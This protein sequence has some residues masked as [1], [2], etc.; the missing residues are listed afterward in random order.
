MIHAFRKGHIRFCPT[1]KRLYDFSLPTFWEHEPV[2]S[3]DS[4][5]ELV[6]R[7]WRSWNR[8]LQSPALI[9]L[10]QLVG[11]RDKRS[12]PHMWFLPQTSVKCSLP[13]SR[14]SELNINWISKLLATGAL[15]FVRE[16]LN[17]P[18][19]NPRSQRPS[20]AI[21]RVVD[22]DR[23]CILS[24]SSI[25][26]GPGTYV[27]LSYVWGPQLG[28]GACSHRGGAISMDELPATIADAIRFVRKIGKRYLWVDR[29]CVE[30]EDHIIKARQLAMMGSIYSSAWV[31]LV[32][33][34]A[35]QSPLP[36][37]S[38]P[39]R[40]YP[41]LPVRG[42]TMIP[43]SDHLELAIRSAS[44]AQRAWTFSE[45]VA[46]P[47]L[48]FFLPHTMVLLTRETYFVE[49]MRLDYLNS[50]IYEDMYIGPNASHSPRLPLLS[51]RNA[52]E[53]LGVAF[54]MYQ[55]RNLTFEQDALAGFG[56]W[57]RE[58][59]VPH[60]C[61]IPWLPYRVELN[62]QPKDFELSVRFLAGL[63]WSQRDRIEHIVAEASAS[64]LKP[65]DGADRCFCAAFPS[66]SWAKC[67]QYAS[68]R[69]RKPSILWSFVC[70]RVDICVD[71]F[72]QVSA[73][74]ALEMVVEHA[75]FAYT[76]TRIIYSGWQGR[77]Q[78]GSG[79]PHQHLNRCGNGSIS[80]QDGPITWTDSAEAYLDLPSCQHQPLPRCTASHLAILI[81][82]DYNGN[83][84]SD[85]G[86]R[87]FWWMLLD[88][89]PNGD[90]RRVG[91]ART[92]TLGGRWHSRMVDIEESVKRLPRTRLIIV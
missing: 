13:S 37:I 22:C 39:R 6:T 74:R 26:T 14:R 56:V 12:S 16:S 48:L 30:Q 49:P 88:K 52:T 65:L 46:S 69:Q 92:G 41:H 87:H 66:W 5:F 57:L 71:Q 47:R 38:T 89:H 72:R 61:G 82:A 21:F 78:D 24:S 55:A 91:I 62:E 63:L 40:P 33:L 35:S 45:A 15:T 81:L 84:A 79:R 20:Q 27:A 58:A 86:W 90:W 7:N 8:S 83:S 28:S 2:A 10:R 85:S 34:E 44:W 4:R 1:L 11:H 31:T 3:G 42:G 32:G 59:G 36:G 80:T 54:D 51:Y 60:L 67:R 19:A 75:E 64:T 18:T 68:L 29:L 73:R 76:K 53:E 77:F 9:T 70:C 17:G 43:P 23:M 50:E 25:A